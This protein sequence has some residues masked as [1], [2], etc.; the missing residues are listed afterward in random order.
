MSGPFTTGV[1]AVAAGLSLGCAAQ[2][3][4]AER[5]AVAGGPNLLFWPP[6]EA[7]S[8]WSGPPQASSED[9]LGAAADRVAAALRAAGYG[10]ARWYAIGARD[11][12]GFAVTTRLEKVDAEGAPVGRRWTTEY[13]DAANLFWLQGAR[14]ARLPGSGRYRVLLVAFTD[15][16]IGP[17]NQAVPWSEETWMSERPDAATPAEAAA[18]TPAGYRV[19]GYV[20]AYES[21]DGA[22]RLLAADPVPARA[23]LEQ[24]GL[25]TLLGPAR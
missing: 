1:V 18:R 5:S 25:S 17:T 15:L 10:E 11:G 6:P 3:R 22:G 2:L 7:S 19:G 23:H 12:H 16:P 9:S 8:T 24:S 20:Y 14:E 21:D 13:P 4:M